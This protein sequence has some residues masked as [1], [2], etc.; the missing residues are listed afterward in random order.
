M[1]SR[2]WFD[3]VV[4]VA[5]VISSTSIF[6]TVII[7]FFQNK[8]EA[9]KN[10]NI[11]NSLLIELDMINSSNKKLLSIIESYNKEN[12]LILIRQA[13]G[14]AIKTMNDDHIQLNKIDAGRLNAYLL[15]M[16]NFDFESSKKLM[17][18][19]NIS[20]DFNKLVERVMNSTIG[21]VS[22]SHDETTLVHDL[23]PSYS[24]NAISELI[25]S[26]K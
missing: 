3:W 21:D 24:I 6:A 23:I 22:F 2:D 19:I 14:V 8:A 1:N 15:R 10:S 18:I 13:T 16:I 20:G 5:S 25:D 7:Y 12:K 17:V 11:K 4:M 26:I 9:K